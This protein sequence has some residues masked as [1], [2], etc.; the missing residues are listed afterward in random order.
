M[1]KDLAF[2]KA[3]FSNV[4]KPNREPLRTLDEMAD[5]FGVTKNQLGALIAHRNGPEPELNHTNKRT[6]NRN[7][8]SPSKMRKWWSEVSQ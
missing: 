2:N 4:G 5:E 8:Y 1:K 7:W 6:Q 3:F